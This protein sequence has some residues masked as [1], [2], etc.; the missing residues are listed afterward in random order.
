MKTKKEKLVEKIGVYIE[1]K[2]SMAPLAARILA[3][4][5][6]QGK[7]G[8]TF[9]SFVCELNASKSTIS[10]HLNTLQAKERVT[11]YTKPGDR[12]KYFI[13]NPNELMKSIEEM[14]ARWREEKELHNEIVA[15]KKE[16]NSQLAVD[17]EDYFDLD[18]HTMYLTYLNQA[19]ELMESLKEKLI[20]KNNQE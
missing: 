17:S 9:D 18:F 2:E 1:H 11:Y 3:T 14:I 8:T 12:K 5:I 7:K 10:T 4:L 16:V 6:L 13:L 20:S 15:Y 19:S